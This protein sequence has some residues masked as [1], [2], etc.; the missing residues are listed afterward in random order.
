MDRQ[1]AAYRIPAERPG[2][3]FAYGFRAAVSTV[4]GKLSAL[5]DASRT[6]DETAVALQVVGEWAFRYVNAASYRVRRR[7]REHAS[8]LLEDLEFAERIPDAITADPVCILEL[9]SMALATA[10]TGSIAAAEAIAGTCTSGAFDRLAWVERS[11]DLFR[12]NGDR[13]WTAEWSEVLR[14]YPWLRCHGIRWPH[15][16]LSPLSE[17]NIY[18]VVDATRAE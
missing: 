17:P 12:T 14:D 3:L 18:F 11:L 8:H 6:A 16:S 10:V 13:R 7:S 2:L 9:G 15:V 1:S 4:Y 5:S